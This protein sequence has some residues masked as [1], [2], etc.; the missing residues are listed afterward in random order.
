[1][2]WILPT[3]ESGHP[4]ENIHFLL[5]PNGFILGESIKIPNCFPM[6][7]TGQEHESA[8]GPQLIPGLLE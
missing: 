1:M 2:Q 8:L 5:V 7:D 4:Q 6:V 3:S